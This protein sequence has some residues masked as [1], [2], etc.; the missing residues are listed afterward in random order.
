MGGPLSVVF[1]GCFMNKLEMDVVVPLNPKFYYRYIDDTYNR[2][3][4]NQP[5]ILFQKLNDYHPNIKFTI[6]VHPKKFLDTDI[7]PTGEGLKFMVHRKENKLPI[8]WSSQVPIR[9]KR[10]VIKGELHRASK[11]SDFI[12]R[13]KE[14]ITER[15][16]HAGFPINF[17][18]STI[19]SFDSFNPDE[20][21][22]PDWLFNEKRSI[23]IRLPFCKRIENVVKKFIDNISYFTK[24]KVDLRIIWNTSKIKS[25]FPLKDKVIHQ[26]NVIYKGSCDVCEKVYIGQTKRNAQTRWKEHLK[27]KSEP[28]K[29]IK[30]FKRH[31]F[32][33]SILCRAPSNTRCRRILEAFYI[34][35]LNPSINDQTDMKQLHLFRHGI[36]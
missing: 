36:T 27:G 29:H 2:R 14:I 23:S 35:K 31:K 1:T 9:Y 8:H 20:K 28:A 7:I 12:D 18:K 32:T 34:S 16:T 13:E 19:S 21:L 24:D 15:F 33:W 11:I 10:N 30:K 22:I 6:E 3:K 26:S 17:I 25:M 4:K 5:D